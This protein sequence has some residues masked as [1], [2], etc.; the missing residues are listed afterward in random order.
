MYISIFIL[1]IGIIFIIISFNKESF[2]DKTNTLLKTSNV[3]YINLKH[4][5]D[6]KEHILGELSKI[7]FSKNKIRRVN[8]I[9]KQNGH[10]GCALSHIKALEEIEKENMEYAF[11]FEDDF[12]W[13]YDIEKTKEILQN[14]LNSK[15]WSICLLSCNGKTTKYSKYTRTVKSCQTTS[16]YII[17]KDYVPILLNHWKSYIEKG[18]LNDETYDS[19]LK[20]NGYETAI[21]QSWKILQKKNK[22]KWKSS[23]PILGKQLPS[24]SDIEKKE[25]HY[26]V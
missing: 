15:D 8:A 18:H 19:N 16:G 1:I 26:D 2:T 7:E 10:Y 9:K 11:V 22:T 14:I 25:V 17:R 3:F 13:K 6:R 21:D 20:V 4:R 24:Y 5:K 23:N 12:V